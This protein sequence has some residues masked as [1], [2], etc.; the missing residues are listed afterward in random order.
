LL[1]NLLGREIYSNKNIKKFLNSVKNEKT[2][3]FV[4]L[5]TRI[6]ISMKNCENIKEI[7]KSNLMDFFDFIIK[8]KGK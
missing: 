2:H 7:F 6:V 4:K 5:F 8:R 3:E 1:T